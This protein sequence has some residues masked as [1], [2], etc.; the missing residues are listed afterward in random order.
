MPR[1]A[2]DASADVRA[3][4][5]GIE[6]FNIAGIDRTVS[7]LGFFKGRSRLDLN[8]LVFEIA[9]WKGAYDLIRVA[10]MSIHRIQCRQRRPE[11]QRSLD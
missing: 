8:E 1:C 5:I 4:E 11:R 10:E 2:V 9:T 3:A 6:S 7:C